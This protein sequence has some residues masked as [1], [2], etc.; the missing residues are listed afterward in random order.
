MNV[1]DLPL[2]LTFDQVAKALGETGG[3]DTKRRHVMALVE[4]KKLTVIDEELPRSL[5]RISRRSLLAYIGEPEPSDP[6][7]GAPSVGTPTL[8]SVRNAS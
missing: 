1:A 3:D 7:V 8:R 5:W 2:V 4:R 6:S